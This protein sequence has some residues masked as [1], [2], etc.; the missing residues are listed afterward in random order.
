[1]SS[2]HHRTSHPG[3]GVRQVPS[4]RGFRAGIDVRISM[5]AN[6]GWGDATWDGAWWPRSW[7]LAVELPELIAELDRRGMR[8]ERFTYSLEGWQPLPRKLAVQGRILR[9]GWFRSMDPQVVCLVWAGSARRADL[10]VVPPETDV[11]TAAR[12]LRL[13][14]TR[15]DLPRSPQSVMAVARATPDPE[16]PAATPGRRG[17]RIVPGR[18]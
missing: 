17:V 14:V 1:M 5:R 18:L 11:V 16:V 4:Q 2:L 15:R 9:T 3:P 6:A 12:A 8:I 10:L 7:D 13:C